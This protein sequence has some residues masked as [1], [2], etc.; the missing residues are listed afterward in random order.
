MITVV[1]RSLL[2]SLFLRFVPLLKDQLKDGTENGGE[3][4]GEWHDVL[5]RATGWNRTL[6]CCGKDTAS[7]HRVSALPLKFVTKP[8]Y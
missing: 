7:V 6:G 5:Q 1:I 3:R 4:E 8:S 2:Q